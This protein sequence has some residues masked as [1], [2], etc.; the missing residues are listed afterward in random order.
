MRKSPL[1]RCLSYAAL[2][3]ATLALALLAL[4]GVATA[5]ADAAVN[6]VQTNAEATPSWAL[7]KLAGTRRLRP[8][9][10][11]PWLLSAEYEQSVDAEK[12]RRLELHAIRLEPD[13][14]QNWEELGSIDL[15]LSRKPAALQDYRRAARY[16]SGF[17]AHYVL[18]NAAFILGDVKM[19]WDQIRI[20]LNVAP[21]SVVPATLANLV[22]LTGARAGR[23][24]GVLPA[25]RPEVSAMAIQY[26]AGAG[27]LP[28]AATLWQ[29][30]SC[31]SY[32]AAACAQAAQVLAS[33]YRQDAHD[34]ESLIGAGAA[35]GTAQSA[36]R[37]AIVVWEQALSRGVITGPQ[38]ASGEVT[39]SRFRFPWR[40]AAFGWQPGI[41]H[42]QRV[43]LAGVGDVVQVRLDGY[44]SS[45]ET[46]LWQWLAVRPGA[47]YTLSLTTRGQNLRNSE[48]IAAAVELP[49][50]KVNAVVPAQPGTTWATNRGTFRAAVPYP[51]VRLVLEYRRPSGVPL[52]Q[53]TVWIRSVHLDREGAPE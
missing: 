47:R 25:K 22:R 7:L 1:Q 4:A 12:A 11:L 23:I 24:A 16:S 20:A 26:L 6:E 19:F 35:G 3:L 49:G 27:Q 30:L 13:S 43:H 2:T 46:L 34:A 48:G 44:E 28:A 41:S 40:L 21:A 42:V 32:D 5:L 36:L 39:D 15:Q 52:M 53:G 29:R 8:D 51:L 9:V 38:V 45:H 18:A 14:W 33:S 31:P 17:R 37:S 10:S 50:G